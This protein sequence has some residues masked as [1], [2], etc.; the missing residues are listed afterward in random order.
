MIAE[1]NWLAAEAYR[2]GLC[3]SHRPVTQGHMVSTPR[4]RGRAGR[5]ELRGR[6]LAAR[7]RGRVDGDRSGK[8]CSRLLHLAQ[9]DD[10][11]PGAARPSASGTRDRACRSSCPP[12]TARRTWWPSRPPTSTCSTPRSTACPRCSGAVRRRGRCNGDLGPPL[13]EDADAT[14]VAGRPATSS[15]RSSPVRSHAPRRARPRPDGAR[16]GSPFGV[17]MVERQRCGV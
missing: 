11:A 7:P 4:Q 10:A 13:L 16:R 14:M 15:G 2:V 8:D 1:P 17:V 12:T 9:R 3:D 5:G 6:A